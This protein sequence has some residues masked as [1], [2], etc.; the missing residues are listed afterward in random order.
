[1]DWKSCSGAFGA[2]PAQ[3]PVRIGA[4]AAGVVTAVGRDAAAVHREIMNGRTAGKI[5]LLP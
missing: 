5:A 4:E 1:V 3:L 2:D